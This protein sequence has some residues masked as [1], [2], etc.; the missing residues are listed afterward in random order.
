MSEQEKP[1]NPN[2]MLIGVGS[3]LTSMMVSGLLLGFLVDWY[4]ATTPLFMLALGALG[5][6]GGLLK[7][8]KMLTHPGMF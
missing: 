2:V 1:K 6:V 4:F 7:A 3:V 5:F 8:F